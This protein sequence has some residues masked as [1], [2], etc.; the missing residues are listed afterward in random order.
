MRLVR[1]LVFTAI[2]SG[3]VLATAGAASAD[4]LVSVPPSPVAPPELVFRVQQPA[5][6]EVLVLF[7]T[8]PGPPGVVVLPPSPV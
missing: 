2:V 4:V 6:A 3:A 5:P 1:R 7:G 8:S